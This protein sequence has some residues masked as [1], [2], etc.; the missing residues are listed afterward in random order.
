MA[1]FTTLNR[2]LLRKIVPQRMEIFFKYTGQPLT[3]YRCGSTDHIEKNCLKQQMWFG[4]IRVEDRR[5]NEGRTHPR[6]TPFSFC[7]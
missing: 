7:P 2:D 4:H 3:C 5:L 6:E 1:K